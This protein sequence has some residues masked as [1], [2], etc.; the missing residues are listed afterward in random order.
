MHILRCMG[1]KFCVKFQRAPLK[2][3]TK[4]WTHTPQNM[5]FAVFYFCVWVTISLDCDVISLSETGPKVHIYRHNVIPLQTHS[6]KIVCH[7]SNLRNHDIFKDLGMCTVHCE[8]GGTK[9]PRKSVSAILWH[10]LI[11]FDTLRSRNLQAKFQCGRW[12]IVHCR[13]SMHGLVGHVHSNAFVTS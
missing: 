4:F 2:F 8:I 12:W 7:S 9:G 10:E 11:G 1:S 6:R 3:H 5:H 13:K